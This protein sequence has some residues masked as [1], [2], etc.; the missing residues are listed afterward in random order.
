MGAVRRAKGKIQSASGPP[1]GRFRFGRNRRRVQS[2]GAMKPI[3]Q[4]A[5]G[6]AN[7]RPAAGL[8]RPTGSDFRCL[9]MGVAAAPVALLTSWVAVLW[10]YVGVVLLS[11]LVAL[12]V[13]GQRQ[14][15]LI[16][17]GVTGGG[18]FFF[19]SAIVV[20]WELT[21]FTPGGRNPVWESVAAPGASALDLQAGW[22][23]L[24]VFLG[25]GLIFVLAWT[26]GRD[27]SRRGGGITGFII[28]SATLVVL[29]FTQ[30]LLPGGN[31]GLPAL[32]GTV[33]FD[34]G[35]MSALTGVAF[36]LGFH[37]CVDAIWSNPSASVP[38]K[39]RSSA[40]VSGLPAGICALWLAILG[41]PQAEAVGCV[42]AILVLAWA[43]LQ[44][45]QP[46]DI[47][48]RV[49]RWILPILALLS[50]VVA[51][52]IVCKM[53]AGTNA[54]IAVSLGWRAVSASPWVGYG[55]A[56]EKFAAQL[57]VTP[58]SFSPQL[59]PSIP[60]NAYIVWL[61]RGGIALALPLGLSGLWI[62][63]S[64][65]RESMQLARRRADADGILIA[66]LFLVALG[67][68]SAAPANIGTATMWAILVGLAAGSV[69]SR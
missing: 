60:P 12:L 57:F 7:A 2:I 22:L 61:M 8:K 18:W 56:C 44:R 67:A 42:G 38:G 16:P 23:G 19:A 64:V 24:I 28:A 15:G 10:V 45:V 50:E 29:D 1:L 62:L 25:L 6:V 31:V 11:T 52:L 4:R 20:V 26:A 9:G 65:Y 69:N 63:T 55:M 59:N 54:E 3:E 17:Q 51:L 48:R 37:R 68:V 30:T 34:T 33:L 53:P 5:R 13:R 27:E 39:R 47:P 58:E 21:P 40:L 66:S 36:L 43:G 41:S 32:A 49:L 46:S 14:R 35:V